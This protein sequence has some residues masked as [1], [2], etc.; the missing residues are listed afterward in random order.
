MTDRIQGGYPMIRSVARWLDRRPPSPPT[1]VVEELPH[2]RRRRTVAARFLRGQ[3]LEIGGLNA[4]LPLP[5]GTRVTHVDRMTPAELT[6]QYPELA[7]QPL[8]PVDV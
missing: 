7:G 4:P 8:A 5:P 1:P 2:L 6:R 3:G